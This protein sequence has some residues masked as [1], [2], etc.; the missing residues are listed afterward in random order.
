MAWAAEGRLDGLTV[1]K[2]RTNAC[3]CADRRLHI[4][5]ANSIVLMLGFVFIHYARDRVPQ[6]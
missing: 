5:R 1:S 4:L 2:R 6:Y 3:M